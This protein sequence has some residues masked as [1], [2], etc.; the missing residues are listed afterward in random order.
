[1]SCNP[2]IG[3]L[4][5]GHLVT[6]SM[7]WTASWAAWP[8]KP[9]SVP[10]PQQ[11]PRACRARP[12]RA[13][14]DRKL[15]REAMQA[16]ISATPNLEVIEAGV[17]DLV[18]DGNEVT[19]VITTDG[20]RFTAG[21][22]VLTTGTFLRGLIHIGETKI[23][24]GRMKR[25]PR[26]RTVGERLYRRTGLRMGRLKTGTPPRLDGRTISGTAAGAARRRSAG[27]VLVPHRAHRH[28]AGALPH[29]HTTEATH[30]II[31]ANLAR[32]PMYSGAIDSI[33]PRYCPS[34]ED[35]VVRFKGARYS[36]DLSRAGRP[37]RRHRL[38][39]RHLHLA[40]RGR[41]TRVP[42]DYSGA[43][44]ARVK[45]PGYTPSSTTSSTP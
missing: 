41:A 42:Q 24:A 16:A 21:A 14:A 32:A 19:G 23:P 13:Q 3:G 8:T 45:R 29:H 20:R 44:T 31:E 15:Y 27:A 25:G 12:S 28:P 34:I 4:G 33:G 39:E 38:S 40:A 43:E 10:R 30:A 6:R 17:E 22:V 9:A 35:K 7:P 1:M 36:S 37:R 11:V 5:K 26:P 2:A 18:V